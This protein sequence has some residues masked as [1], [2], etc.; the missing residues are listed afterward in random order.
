MSKPVLTYFN[1][2]GRAEMIRMLFNAA[3]VEF[4]DV[5][6]KPN[7]EGVEGPNAEFMEF[8]KS[9]KCPTGQVPFLE[10]DGKSYYQTLAIMRMLGKKYNMAGKNADE[11]YQLDAITATIGDAQNAVV[12]IMF[13]PFSDEEKKKKM[14]EWMADEMKGM[15]RYL[16]YI[17]KIAAGSSTG[18]LVGDSLT[19]ADI[20]AYDFFTTMQGRVKDQSGADIFEK[21]PALAKFCNGIAEGKLKTYLA[22]RP[23]Q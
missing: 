3:G 15:P 10:M 19:Y 6:F 22:N 1:V 9:G 14:G 5:R 7:A 8:K 23:A 12:G 18:F 13:G 20:Y 17:E 21:T 2:R 11:E 16:G 4:E